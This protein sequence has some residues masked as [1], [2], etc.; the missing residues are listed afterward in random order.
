MAALGFSASGAVADPRQDRVAVARRRHHRDGAELARAGRTAREVRHRCAEATTTCR[1]SRE[2]EEIPC[3]ALTGP[4]SGSD[5]ATMRDIGVVT[6]WHARGQARRSAS[7]QSGTSATSRSRPM[8][9]LLG[10][11]FRLFDPDNLLGNGEDIGITLALIPADHPG[12]RHRPPAFALRRRVPERPDSGQRR[13]H[14]DR[15][16]HRRRGAVGQGWRMLMECL[17]AGRAISLPSSATAGAK[18][19][20]ASP[21]AY[22]RIRKQFGLPMAR[23]EGVEEPLARIIETAYVH[24][25]GAR[26]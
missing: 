7:A 14:P 9:T 1:G 4:T 11:A 8:A 24:R 6:R 16:D 10:L 15:L 26:A 13:L 21:S 5:A 17:A 3:F 25:G 2:G 18:R 19:C 22:A 23:M 20:C 12:V